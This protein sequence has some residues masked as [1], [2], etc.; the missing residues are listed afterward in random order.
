MRRAS[1]ELP[2]D[3][4]IEVEGIAGARHPIGPGILRIGRQ[5]D[6]D[7]CLADKTVHRYHAVIHRAGE[8]SSSP[9]TSVVRPATE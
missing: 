7:L 6:N 9:P 5:D 4:W 2:Y 1:P 8:A 3:G